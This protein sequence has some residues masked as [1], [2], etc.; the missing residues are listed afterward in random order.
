MNHTQT[1]S[2]ISGL[3][4]VLH[5]PTAA[6]VGPQFKAAYDRALDMLIVARL[7]PTPLQV[8][9][10]FLKASL[11]LARFKAVIPSL[12]YLSA[13]TGIAT[14]HVCNAIQE[15][16]IERRIFF[17]DPPND[18]RAITKEYWFNV[19][20]SGWQLKQRKLKRKED[21]LA[22]REQLFMEY[23]R[24]VTASG[25][26]SGSLLENFV[27][28][29]GGAVETQINLCGGLRPPAVT[30]R[31]AGDSIAG[32]KKKSY[33]VHP[34]P[35]SDGSLGRPAAA[36]TQSLAVEQSD[37]KNIATVPAS[38]Q[39]QTPST[40]LKKSEA[41]WAWLVEVDNS[42]EVQK[43]AQPWCAAQ[44]QALCLS[45]PDYILG[46][47]KGCWRHCSSRPGEK[48]NHPLSFLARVAM[49][50]GKLQDLREIRRVVRGGVALPTRLPIA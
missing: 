17:C 29:A 50:D 2:P 10:V 21:I 49:N 13:A 36:T 44:W 4:Q 38:S 32:G 14:S 24:W 40:P 12:E 1:D 25:P 15:L 39:V 18:S 33:P 16:V 35:D 11:G 26:L 7:S 41:A 23:D 48:I 31:P 6:A 5:V 27:E 3:K 42:A 45:N 37:G 8:G 19:L 43:F 30:E 46:Y 22:A 47:L 20:S 9:V 34:G 28:T